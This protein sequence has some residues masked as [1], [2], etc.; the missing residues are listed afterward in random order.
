MA[1][2]PSIPTLFTRSQA[3]KT[4]GNVEYIEMADFPH[5]ILPTRKDILRN[6]LYLL[7]P[8]RAGQVQRSKEEAGRILA[9]VVQEHWLFC[10]LYAIQSKHIKKHIL[11][12]YSDFLSLLNK[13]KPKKNAGYDRRVELFNQNAENLFDIFCVDQ[14]VRKKLETLAHG[15]KMSEIEWKFLNDQRSDRKMICTEFL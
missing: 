11:R 15:V 9:E 14:A 4:L 2:A 3:K 1:S 5:G 13:R 6:M 12:L 8:K 7:Q 10:N